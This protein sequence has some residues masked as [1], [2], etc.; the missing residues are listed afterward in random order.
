VGYVRLH[1]RNYNHWFA[2]SQPFERYDYLYRMDE[3]EPW[4]ERVQR[5]A[6]HAESTFVITNNHFEGKGVAN[7]FEIEAL[8]TGNLIPVPETLQARYPELVS[9]SSSESAGEI[10]QVTGGGTLVASRPAEPRQGDFS[11]EP[12]P[13]AQREPSPA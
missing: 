2:H 11:F 3:L 5:V 1:G 12:E 4:V 9:I 13:E 7:A 8:L 10:P 6:T